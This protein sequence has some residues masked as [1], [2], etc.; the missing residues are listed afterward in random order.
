MAPTQGAGPRKL[1]N[2][3][4]GFIEYCSSLYA[5]LPFRKWAAI[6]VISSAMERRLWVWTRGRNMYPNLYVFLVGPPG[7]GKGL[8]LDEVNRLL[9]AITGQ[10]TPADL[11]VAPTSVTTSSLIDVLSESKRKILRPTEVPP[12]VEFHSLQIVVPEFSDFAPMYDPR[13]M[14]ALQ[15]FYDCS[16]TSVFGERRRTKDSNIK[17]TNPQ[18][19]LIAGTTPSYLNTFMPD[20]AWDQG[21]ISRTI[22]VYSGEEIVPSLFGEAKGRES[23]G[24]ELKADLKTIFSLYGKL[25][26]TEEA[27]AT[28]QK[29]LDDKQPPRPDHRRLM[30]YN[31]R[32]TGHLIKLCMVASVATSNALII[33]LEHVKMALD[34]LTT[35]E[36]VMPDIFKS[37]S[38]IGDGAAVEDCW[39]FMYKEYA[40]NHEPIPEHRLIEFLRERMPSYSVLQAM[41]VMKKSMLVEVVDAGGPMGTWRYKP[42]AKQ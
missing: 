11:H 6:S 23:L 1:K 4:D 40:K 36:N 24:L 16:D 15:S 8:V 19:G 22:M 17:I 12:Y 30:H 32:R 5:P 9:T 27:R 20:G 29:W 26:W 21:F 42:K 13:F 25:Q 35:A 18:L 10:N 38:S 14:S 2:W 41:E 34:W 39:F 33:E 7:V 3:I 28:I 31:S 37:A